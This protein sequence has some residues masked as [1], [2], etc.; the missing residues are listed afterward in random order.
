MIARSG[1]QPALEKPPGAP[2]AR[3]PRNRSRDG[4]GRRTRLP[5]PARKPLLAADTAREIHPTKSNS[6]SPP[7][8]EKCRRYVK[9]CSRVSSVGGRQN[10]LPPRR[11]APALRAAATS[12]ATN[13]RRHRVSPRQAPRVRR[14]PAS[15]T[16]DLEATVQLGE[17]IEQGPGSAQRLR[18]PERRSTEGPPRWAH[19]RAAPMSSGKRG[20]ASD[21]GRRRACRGRASREHAKRQ[22]QPQADARSDSSSSAEQPHAS[23]RQRDTS[24]LRSAH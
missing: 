22:T 13:P 12:P 24:G 18:A 6:R 19:R 4:A 10:R 16:T 7:R 1:R 9:R 8:R 14:R 17:V 20:S 23:G 2:R 3:S 15:R 11:L 21:A 5:V